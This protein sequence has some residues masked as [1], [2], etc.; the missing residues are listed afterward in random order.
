MY[1]KNSNTYIHK[2]IWL[3]KKKLPHQ[4]FIEKGVY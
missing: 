3:C 1:M 4:K 2:N